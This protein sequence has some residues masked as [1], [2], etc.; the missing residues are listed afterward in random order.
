VLSSPITEN[1][2][3]RKLLVSLCGLFH[4]LDCS[5]R[6]YVSS[7]TEEQRT[8]SG[9][10]SVA[11][12][13]REGFDEVKGF[14]GFAP[15]MGKTGESHG[16]QFGAQCASL[17]YSTVVFWMARGKPSPCQNH[18]LLGEQQGEEIFRPLPEFEALVGIQDQPLNECLRLLTTRFPNGFDG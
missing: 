13:D 17:P 14:T 7:I 3:G 11:G 10:A 6:L 18:R 5:M 12:T 4:Y 16:I 2:T 15:V 1:F 8:T 9:A